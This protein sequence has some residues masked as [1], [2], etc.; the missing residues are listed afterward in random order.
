MIQI[1]LVDIEASEK[2]CDAFIALGEEPL[3]FGLDEHGRLHLLMGDSFDHMLD[4]DNDIDDLFY[5]FVANAF[6][7][8]PAMNALVRKMYPI[9]KEMMNAA[10]AYHGG[11]LFRAR[12]KARRLVEQM[13]G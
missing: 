3:G 9:F 12:D 4:G 2:I 13:E 11:D 1:T 6:I 8:L 7:Q 10:D 5:A